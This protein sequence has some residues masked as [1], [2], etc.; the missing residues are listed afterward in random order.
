MVRLKPYQAPLK[1]CP[2]RA[3][4]CRWYGLTRTSL[5]SRTAPLACTGT[6]GTAGTAYPLQRDS[7][8]PATT[9][10]PAESHTETSV[11]TVRPTTP[12]SCLCVALSGPPC[13]LLRHCTSNPWRESPPRRIG[14]QK[15]H[16]DPSTSLSTDT[17]R[18]RYGNRRH[19]NRP[20]HRASRRATRHRPN[21]DV[22]PR[23]AAARSNRSPSAGSAGS[24]P[25]ASPSTSTGSAERARDSRQRPE[26]EIIRRDA[27]RTARRASIAAP[28]A[29]G[30][31]G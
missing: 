4:R 6:A 11:H 16:E 28:T 2:R 9:E 10:R 21:A 7:R 23:K 27:S 1:I 13:G 24:R 26:K 29:T 12:R 3:G 17:G 5:P 20:D 8:P 30:I 25:P 14:P 31:G 19:A 22:R 18:H 15:G